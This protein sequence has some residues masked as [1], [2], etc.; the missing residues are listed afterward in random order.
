MGL[1][2]GMAIGALNIDLLAAQEGHKATGFS[3]NHLSLAHST[4][5]TFDGQK[6]TAPSSTNG[7]A[8]CESGC[9]F[10]AGTCLA[11][12]QT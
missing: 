9:S 5:C 6:C 2:D 11:Q 3:N 1:E 12:D 7:R 10:A 8:Q 4:F